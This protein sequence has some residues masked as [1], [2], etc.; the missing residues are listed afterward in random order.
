[1]ISV[2]GSDTALSEGFSGIT[3]AKNLQP[4]FYWSSTESNANQ[5][6]LYYFDP[7]FSCWSYETKNWVFG[8]VRACLAF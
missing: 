4:D 7:D 5:A 8:Y 2:A 3:G 6:W 1:M